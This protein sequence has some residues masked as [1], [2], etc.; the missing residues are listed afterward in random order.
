MGDRLLARASLRSRVED[1]MKQNV[2]RTDHLAR[3]VIGSA[4]VYSGL[5]RIGHG[6]LAPAALIGGGAAVLGTTLARGRMRGMNARSR[7]LD[8]RGDPERDRRERTEALDESIP[9][10]S[11]YG[12]TFQTNAAS[13][14]PSSTSATT[15]PGPGTSPMGSMR[16]SADIPSV[17]TGEPK[18]GATAPPSE[19][20]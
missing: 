13:G 11:P 16:T 17:V 14:A 5:R 19:R 1:V 20:R 12:G 10:P 18:G 9:G 4:L 6:R 7:Q 15:A 3:V 8:L 2:G